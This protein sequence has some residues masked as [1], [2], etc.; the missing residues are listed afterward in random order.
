M[1][2]GRVRGRVLCRDG[3]C[4]TLLRTI[5]EDVAHCYDDYGRC[6]DPDG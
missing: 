4:S 1:T 6:E 2:G 3:T 5:E